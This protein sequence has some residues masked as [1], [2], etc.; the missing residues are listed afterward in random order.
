MSHRMPFAPL[1]ATLLLA[2]LVT[3]ASAAA[4]P[5]ATASAQ[6]AAATDKVYPPLPSLAMLPP[7]DNDDE[8]LPAPGG[9]SKKKHGRAIVRVR[10]VT[11]AVKLIVTDA[12]RA[13]LQDIEK[14][15]DAALAK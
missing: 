9:A 5:Q 4:A 3:D 8:P 12:S 7:S 10:Q 2:G 11:P 15:L 1:L 14:Q 6:P 13:Y